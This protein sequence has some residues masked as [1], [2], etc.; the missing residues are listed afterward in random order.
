M[1]AQQEQFSCY[2]KECKTLRVLF[3]KK[4]MDDPFIGFQMD[5]LFIKTF[6]SNKYIY[7]SFV[8]MGP[9]PLVSD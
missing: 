9:L 3:S 5:Q 1:D 8:Q 7:F 2:S 4:N 6:I